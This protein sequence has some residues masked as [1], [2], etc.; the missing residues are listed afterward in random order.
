MPSTKNTRLVLA[1]TGILGIFA[2]LGASFFVHNATSHAAAGTNNPYVLNSNYLSTHHAKAGF[3]NLPAQGGGRGEVGKI[4]NGHPTSAEIPGIEGVSNW[5]GTFN[6]PGF[7][8]KGNPTNTWFYNMIGNPPTSGKTTTFA[9]PIIP[10]KVELLDANGNPEFTVDPAGDARPVV[11]SP[12]FQDAKYSSSDKPTQFT[13]AVQRAEFHNVEST[14]WHTLLAPSV[15]PEVTLTVPSGKWFVG[16]NAD[17]SV[18][19]TLMDFDTFVNEMFPSSFPVDNSTIIGQEELNG[20]MTTS[21]ISTFLFDNLYLFENGDVNQCCV[22]GFHEPDIEPGSN[23]ALANYDMIYASYITPGLFLGGAQDIT[24]LSHEMSETFNDPFSGVYFPYDTVPWW[25]SE[26]I[27]PTF[28][29]F[30]NC[31]DNL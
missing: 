21:N 22:L 31:Q 16:L 28:G 5:G 29:A 9:V 6:E 10:V 25:L 30:A 18:A 11:N 24:G 1:G 4:N 8:P 20:T 13:D 17:G 15:K 2:I 3:A 7:D 27:S 23:G 12:I 19:F 14:N 26:A